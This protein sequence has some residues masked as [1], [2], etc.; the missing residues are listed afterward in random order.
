VIF[1]K[2]GEADVP[3]PALVRGLLER[4]A[5]TLPDEIDGWTV[6]RVTKTP[7]YA[8]VLLVRTLPN[9]ESY[10]EQ[11]FDRPDGQWRSR[12]GSGGSRGWSGQPPDDE[13][14]VVWLGHSGLMPRQPSE[15]IVRVVRAKASGDVA[16]IVVHQGGKAFEIA[17]VEEGW[18]HVVIEGFEEATI[19]AR[20][21]NDGVVVDRDGLPATFHLEAARPPHPR[22]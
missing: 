15:S 9:E 5:D 2:F 20:D 10:H 18:F 13:P 21:R 22:P 11:V 7:H 3:D 4:P 16:R 17:P 12:G 6:A 1:R 8:V 19:T 14:P